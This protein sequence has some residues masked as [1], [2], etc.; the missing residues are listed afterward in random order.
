MKKKMIASV[1][2]SKSYVRVVKINCPMRF[3]WTKQGEFDGVEY[4]LSGKKLTGYQKRLL[5]E[6]LDVMLVMMDL[7]NELNKNKCNETPI[8][9]YI[10]R[11]FPDDTELV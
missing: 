1:E 11:A 6:T 10:K 2:R 8:P 7:F 4:D 5:N 3:Y 9:D